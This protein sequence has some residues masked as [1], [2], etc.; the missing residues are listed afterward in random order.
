MQIAALEPHYSQLAHAIQPIAQEYHRVGRWDEATLLLEAGLATLDAP[1]R[2]PLQAILGDILIKQN[3]PDRAQAILTEARTTLEGG[4]DQLTLGEILYQWGEYAYFR[5]FMQGEGD[6]AQIQAHHQAALELREAIGDQAGLTHSLSR[7]GV[8]YERQGEFEKA[9]QLYERALAIG[10][11]IGYLAGI[12][13]PLTH[14]AVEHERN[15]ELAQALAIF[16]RVVSIQ[17]T[18]GY[19]DALV[20]GLGNLASAQFAL[21]HDLE[22]ALALCQRALQIAENL[23]FV[24]GEIRTLFVMGDLYRQAGLPDQAAPMFERVIARAAPIG[25]STFQGMAEQALSKLKAQ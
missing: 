16:R 12:T 25:F 11:Q 17:E 22:Q 9:H 18:D 10:E 14:L 7:V 23:H 24:M 3:Q 4:A 20:Y 1:L 6:L 5:F 21:N 8:I 15:H 19:Q 2:P 13:R